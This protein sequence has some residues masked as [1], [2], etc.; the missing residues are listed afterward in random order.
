MTNLPPAAEAAHAI[1]ILRTALRDCLAVMENELEG[2]KVIQPEMEAARVALDA[3]A[4]IGALAT[5]GEG[6]QDLCSA[7]KGMEHLPGHC[8][9]TLESVPVGFDAGQAGTSPWEM[10]EHRAFSKWVL[11]RLQGASSMGDLAQAWKQGQGYERARAERYRELSEAP[12]RD[13]ASTPDGMLAGQLKDALGILED[14][15]PWVRSRQHIGRIDV[16]FQRLGKHDQGQVA[17]ESAALR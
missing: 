11:V 14:L 7:G 4:C 6:P 10:G 8:G 15:R 9:G 12:A 1:E 5:P 2:L 17:I 13:A 16:L 3:T